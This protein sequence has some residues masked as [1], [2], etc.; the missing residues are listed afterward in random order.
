MFD[1]DRVTR[2]LCIDRFALYQCLPL[3]ACIVC[4][5]Y[6]PARSREDDA[7]HI[8][9][10]TKHT[11]YSIIIIHVCFQVLELQ[12]RGRVQPVADAVPVDA[13]SRLADELDTVGHV[14]ERRQEPRD[15]CR[16]GL[17]VVRYV[18]DTV[19]YGRE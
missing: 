3:F 6:T 1:G 16:C 5:V 13:E 15:V 10:R 4:H 14:S 9:Y 19:G 12:L 11:V 18:Q 7:V 2:P 17:V 8:L